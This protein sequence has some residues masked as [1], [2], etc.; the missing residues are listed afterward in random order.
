MVKEVRSPWSSEGNIRPIEAPGRSPLSRPRADAAGHLGPH[1]GGKGW[2]PLARR[3]DGDLSFQ[4]SNAQ[5]SDF[6]LPV[7][8]RRR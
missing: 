1:V 7:G 5:P 3:H 8:D 4:R 6:G 2:T